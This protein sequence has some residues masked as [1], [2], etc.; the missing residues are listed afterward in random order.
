MDVISVQ[1]LV[2]KNTGRGWLSKL[3]VQGIYFTITSIYPIFGGS[4]AMPALILSPDQEN[5]T[6]TFSQ[7]HR[8][9]HPHG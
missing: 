3:I 6:L 1:L 8:S 4:I 2:G 5:R 9:Y 7:H